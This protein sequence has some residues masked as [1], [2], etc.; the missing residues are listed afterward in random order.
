MYGI[1]EAGAKQELY[2]LKVTVVRRGDGQTQRPPGVQLVLTLL[3]SVPSSTSCLLALLTL[4]THG[5][6][7]PTS[8]GSAKNRE[9][10]ELHRHPQ[11]HP[12]HPFQPLALPA[13]HIARWRLF[14]RPSSSPS[15]SSRPAP[16]TVTSS[17][18]PVISPYPMT[19]TAALL[20][21]GTLPD[22]VIGSGDT[23]RGADGNL[24][25]VLQ[26]EQSERHQ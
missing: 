2:S 18:I 15:G 7:E 24:A 3:G 9:R 26:P 22:T 19:L 12:S 1:W 4:L 21:D 8:R 13:S 25:L 16:P 5:S 20:P 17:L 6:P 23:S 11:E 14:L 10:R